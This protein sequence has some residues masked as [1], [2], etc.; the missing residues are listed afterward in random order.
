MV[1]IMPNLDYL[2]LQIDEFYIIHQGVDHIYLLIID[3]FEEK[4]HALTRL[5]E[6]A[7]GGILR[8]FFDDIFTVSSTNYYCIIG[9]GPAS[10]YEL[11]T[12]SSAAEI[13]RLIVRFSE[14]KKC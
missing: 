2:Y 8:D 3:E 14:E 6:I 7:G 10:G 5:L 13:R 4:Y 11:S 9:N 1:G 12:E